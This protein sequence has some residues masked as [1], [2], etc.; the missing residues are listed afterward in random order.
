MT[1]V[2]TDAEFFIYASYGLAGLVL[3]GLAIWTWARLDRA[4]KRLNM[5]KARS[6]RD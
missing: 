5:L 2:V 3:F 6:K 1:G 4:K